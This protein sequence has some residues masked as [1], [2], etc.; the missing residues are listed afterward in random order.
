M[1]DQLAPRLKARYAAGCQAGENFIETS[2]LEP[3]V[4]SSMSSLQHRSHQQSGLV[5]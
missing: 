3:E 5:S 1:L 2:Y 4:A